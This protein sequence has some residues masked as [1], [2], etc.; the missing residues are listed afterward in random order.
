M[1]KQLLFSVTAKDCT[2]D[3]IRGS[4][5]G[6][7]KR[8]KTSSAVRCH[9][10]DSG[11]VGYAEDTRSQLKNKRLALPRKGHILRFSIPSS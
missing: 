3:Y 6:G 9:H 11:A 5:K 8:N 10:K 1:S 7:Q 2:W 4:G